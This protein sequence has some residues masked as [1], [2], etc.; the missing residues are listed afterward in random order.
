MA[1]SSRT[2][3]AWVYGG[4]AALALIWGTQFLVIRIG[5]EC[6]PPLLTLCLRFVVLA[7]SA[8][9]LVLALRIRESS[10]FIGSRIALGISQ[11]LTL[12]LLYWSQRF[13]P[14]SL[15]ATLFMLSPLFVVLMAPRIL[16][17]ERS[18]IQTCLSIGLGFAGAAMIVQGRANRS[19]L[20]G[21]ETALIPVIAVIVAA[22]FGAVNRVISKKLT[23]A[24]AP[25]L[26]LRD[27]GCI[28][29]LAS[30]IGWFLFERNEAVRFTPKAVAAVVYLGLVASL[31][32][33]TISLLIL[34]RYRAIATSYLQF[35]TALIGFLTGVIVGGEAVGGQAVLGVSAIVGGL[36]LLALPTLKARRLPKGFGNEPAGAPTSTL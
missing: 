9:G 5:Q 7:V 24:F 15:A 6:V 31:A 3:H 13:L 11:A 10:A 23:P 18:S 34:R 22:F 35:V 4:L 25:P 12:G 2:P 14:S 36:F 33:S 20:D 27:L 19:G 17:G 29:A 26:L 16:E 30:G 1:S 28:V 21:G 32:A 8:Q